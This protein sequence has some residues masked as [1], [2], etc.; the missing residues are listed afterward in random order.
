MFIVYL[1]KVDLIK[2]IP[3]KQN[4]LLLILI[5]VSP[6]ILAQMFSVGGETNEEKRLS[7][8]YFRIGASPVSFN[9][10][11]DNTGPNQQDRLDFESTALTI[12]FE[13]PALSAS[14]SFANGLT[15]A[16]KERYLNL[17]IDYL[18]RLYISRRP[19]FKAGIPFGLN[20]NLVNV[21]NE[22]VN[23]DFSQTVIGF[24]AGA[25]IS[26]EPGSKVSFTAEG[27]PAYGFSNS[28]GGLFGG[29]NKSLLLRGRLNLLGLIGNTSI[30]F[31]YDYKFSS[32]NLDVDDFDYDLTYHRIT[33]G[34]SL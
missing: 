3:M 33:L 8:T 11:G 25:F 21:Q 6:N 27:L 30:S 7:S 2:F 23:N 19:S 5:F 22:D 15:G 20:S 1:L 13:N 9:Y 32:Y 34:I 12:F 31:G 17:S 28:K 16:D 29:S 4:F 18:N 24:G 10:S 14:L 26:I